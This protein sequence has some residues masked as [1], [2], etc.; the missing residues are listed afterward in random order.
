MALMTAVRPTADGTLTPPNAVSASDT[1][2]ANDLGSRGAYLLVT[3]G[4]GSPIN[5]TI[6]D[7]SRTP[8]GN[9]ATTAAKAVANGTTR[10]FYISP[11]AVD[12]T[13]NVVTVAFSGTTS[14][15]YQLLPVG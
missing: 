9:A 3:N 6:S 4:G 14:V 15:T 13:T 12:F 11:A 8:A 1:I 10:S 2:S 5:V 7:A